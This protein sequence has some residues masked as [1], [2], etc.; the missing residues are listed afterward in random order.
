MPKLEPKVLQR[1]L[2][3]GYL[4]PVYWLYGSE[5]MKMREL[6]AR[7][8]RTT[9]ASEQAPGLCE[10]VFDAM[11]SGT[12]VSL[13]LDA[14]LSPALGGGVRLIIVREAHALKEADE[15]SA[16]FGSRVKLG[17]DPLTSVCVFLSKDLDGRKK[18]SKALIENAAVV[19]CE[20]V[21]ED[22]REAWVQYL[23][24]RRS[25][26]L[27]AS[28]VATLAQL[29]PWNL[30][31]ID[32]ELEKFSVSGSTDVIFGMGVGPGSSTDEFL[33]A[34]FA[35][36]TSRTL[37]GI[38][39]FADR[40]DEALPLLGLLAWNVRHVAL[41]VASRENGARSDGIKLSP[42]VADRLKAWSRN[43]KLVEILEI[44]RRLAELDFAL[45]QTPLLPLGVWATLVL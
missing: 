34:F 21:P 25:M 11:D 43:W 27:D 30:D 45:K 5:R 13:I 40:P 44:Q 19:A 22:E 8:R 38:Q 41:L 26:T 2:E 39:S 9:L 35:R 1:E 18:F 16:L 24:K 36:D 10:D 3:Q 20:E 28:V 23:A 6:L 33:D 37:R 31:M 4:W 15:L 17:T 32:Q 12:D 29:E 7:I 42:Y 14:A